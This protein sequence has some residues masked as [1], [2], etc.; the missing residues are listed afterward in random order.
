MAE[1]QCFCVT[2]LVMFDIEHN[3]TDSAGA[4][5]LPRIESLLR[6]ALD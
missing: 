2:C 6:G 5:V 4:H 1:A 3:I